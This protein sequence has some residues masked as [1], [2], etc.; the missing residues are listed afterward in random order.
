MSAQMKGGGLDILTT[1]QAA[2]KALLKSDTTIDL[3]EHRR[4]EALLFT[5]ANRVDIQSERIIRRIEV[6][7]LLAVT[8]RMV[9]KYA[10]RGMLKRVTLPEQSRANGFRESDVR[11]LISGRRN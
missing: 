8:P 7:R 9:D 11:A 6:A 2:I 4:L 10:Q 5:G 1:T 3:G